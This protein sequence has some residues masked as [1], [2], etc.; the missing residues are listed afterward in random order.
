M[1]QIS[2]PLFT[3]TYTKNKNYEIN[4]V[5][6]PLNSSIII[7]SCYG[8]ASLNYGAADDNSDGIMIIMN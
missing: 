1:A 4:F 6:Y 2:K 3:S 8:K 5:Y 7:D